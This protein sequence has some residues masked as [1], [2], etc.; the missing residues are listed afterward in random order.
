MSNS[1]LPEFDA[2]PEPITMDI[3]PIPEET[4]EI[5]EPKEE[6]EEKPVIET[7]QEDIFVKDEGDPPVKP[8]K[9]ENQCQRPKKKNLR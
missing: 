1:I 8:K 7:S 2:E 9:K 4:E 5:I 3:K 6:V